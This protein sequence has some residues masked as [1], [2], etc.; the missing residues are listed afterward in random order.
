MVTANREGHT[1]T[2]NSSYFRPVEVSSRIDEESESGPSDS[3]NRPGNNLHEQDP[4]GKSPQ[5]PVKSNP[6]PI[7]PVP[8][9]MNPKRSAGIEYYF[10][11]NLQIFFHYL[12]KF[13]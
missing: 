11:I 9:M 6:A 1:I 2:R 5:S 13:I 3:Q 7:S 4:P 8:P 10:D 12:V